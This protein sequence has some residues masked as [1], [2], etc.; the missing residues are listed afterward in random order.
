M[1]QIKPND[2]EGKARKVKDIIKP[3]KS[4]SDKVSVRA[5]LEQ[6]QAQAY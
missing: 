3:A 6:M 4:I 5:A 1:E 2:S